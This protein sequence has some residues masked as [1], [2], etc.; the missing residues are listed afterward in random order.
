MKIKI[1]YHSGAG[2][3]KTIAEVFYD[4]LKTIY[5]CDLEGITL[6]YDYDKLSAFDFIIFGFPTYHCDPSDSMME[7][8]Q[9]FPKLKKTTKAFV[10]TTYALY[11]GNTERF[12]IKACRGKNIAIIGSSGYRAPAT[13]GALFFPYF[14]FIFNYGKKVSNRIAADIELI[15]QS[16]EENFKENEYIPRFKLYTILNYPNKALAKFFS[17]KLKLVENQCIECNKCVNGCIRECW[18]ATDQLPLWKAENCEYCFKCVHH[19]P[20]SAI[21]L[22]KKTIERKK[23]NDSFYQKMKVELLNS[24]SE[25][26]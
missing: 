19:C 13:D 21:T 10:F 23:F 18:K 1:L 4:K 20:G 3:T 26:N 9:K 17:P 16:V 22:S 14:K 25:N 24:F 11:T 6:E 12:F 7:F 15:N 5:A 2:S 8:I